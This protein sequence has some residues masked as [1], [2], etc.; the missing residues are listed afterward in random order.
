MRKALGTLDNTH[1]MESEGPAKPAS[2][3][4]SVTEESAP[5][6]SLDTQE[7]QSGSDVLLSAGKTLDALLNGG[8]LPTLQEEVAPAPAMAYDPRIL[9]TARSTGKKAAKIVN[10]LP[11]KVKEQ[12]QQVSSVR[13]YKRSRRKQR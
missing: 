13:S 2:S 4:A 12:L 3:P 1:F 8:A 9:L 5:E 11:E 6:L 10:F 7:G